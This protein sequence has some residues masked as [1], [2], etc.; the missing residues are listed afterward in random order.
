M[1]YPTGMRSMLA[2]SGDA[3]I[4]ELQKSNDTGFWTVAARLAKEG[5]IAPLASRGIIG[6][7]TA[8]T[9]VY[10]AETSQGGSG[11]GSGSEATAAAGV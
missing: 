3:F 1:G 4:E 2:Q 7:V 5:Y 11:G 8:A 6:Q 10:D 9:V